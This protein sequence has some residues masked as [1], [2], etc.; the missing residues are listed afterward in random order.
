VPL[1]IGGAPRD[2]RNLF[3]QPTAKVDLEDHLHKAV[4]SGQIPLMDAQAKMRHNWTH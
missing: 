4:C 1:S 2:P 3:P